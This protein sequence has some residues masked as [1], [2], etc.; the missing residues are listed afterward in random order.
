MALNAGALWLW[1]VWARWA[2][3]LCLYLLCPRPDRMGADP[4]REN[5]MARIEGGIVI[6][7]PVDMVFDY[8]TDQGNEPQCN[9]RM[10]RVEKITAGPV[11]NGTQFC[12]PV[13]SMGRT[14]EVLSEPHPASRRPS[15]LISQRV[16]EACVQDAPALARITEGAL[17]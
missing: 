3:D 2:W 9:P 1:R 14:A 17:A 16:G 10:V 8:I 12:S 7:R 13:A 15:T 11:G 6:G 4:E 5:G